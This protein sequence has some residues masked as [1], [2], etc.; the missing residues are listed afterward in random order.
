[1]FAELAHRRAI[2]LADDIFTRKLSG[3]NACVIRVV[4]CCVASCVSCLLFS[5]DALVFRENVLYD[6]GKLVGL[7]SNTDFSKTDEVCTSNTN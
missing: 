3:R 4:Y 5:G 6:L 1:M 2:S 7:L